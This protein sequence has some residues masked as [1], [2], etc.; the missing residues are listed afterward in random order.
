M[1]LFRFQAIFCIL[2]QNVDGSSVQ[3]QACR[4]LQFPCQV[5]SSHTNSCSL[6]FQASQQ[7]HDSQYQVNQQREM[8]DRLQ[9]AQQQLRNMQ[10]S[11]TSNHELEDLTTELQEYREEN[12][13]LQ[14]RAHCW[15]V[16]GAYQFSSAR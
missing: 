15:G 14:V 1:K 16:F 9:A 12:R 13:R 6:R 7:L 3:R 4:C 8:N 2:S 10:S 5:G 11:L